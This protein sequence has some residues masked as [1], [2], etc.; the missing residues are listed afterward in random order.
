MNL[1]ADL[2][3]DTDNAQALLSSLRSSAEHR[4]ELPEAPQSSPG[5]SHFTTA[6]HRAIAVLERREGNFR[7]EVRSLLDAVHEH[8]TDVIQTDHE[9]GHLLRRL[10]R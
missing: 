2:D 1:D 4:A 8:L 6:A 5:L 7:A 3:L 9:Q 10:Q